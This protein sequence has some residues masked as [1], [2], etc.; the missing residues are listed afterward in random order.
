MGYSSD[1]RSIE[2]ELGAKTLERWLLKPEKTMSV[3][4]AIPKERAQDERRVATVLFADLVGFTRLGEAL[5]PQDLEEL[6]R[7]LAD[8]ARDVSVHP[9]RFVKTIGDEVMFVALP[10]RA[11]ETALALRDLGREGGG[12]LPV[13][14][15]IAA[16]PVV[17]HVGDVY[18]L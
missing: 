12:L 13:R 18:G 8:L 10:D 4:I 2:F 15:G 3:S 5:A 16:G 1:L 6:A 7:R 9:V 17:S 11:A 14:V